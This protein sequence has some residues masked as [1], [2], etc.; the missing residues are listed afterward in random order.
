MPGVDRVPVD[1]EVFGCIGIGAVNHA[2]RTPVHRPAKRAISRGRLMMRQNKRNGA[3][4]CQQETRLSV[5]WV[6]NM[7]D[8]DGGHQA[9]GG[10][11]R[12]DDRSDRYFADKVEPFR[13]LYVPDQ[14]ILS[15]TGCSKRLD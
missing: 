5:V 14:H 1:S 7:Y 15:D 3:R 12:S 2:R 8:V 13:E 10:Y 4:Q 9:I 6:V 11:R